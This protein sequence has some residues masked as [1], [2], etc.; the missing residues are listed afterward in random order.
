[1]SQAEIACETGI[2]RTTITD[3]LARLKDHGTPNKL[4]YPGHPRIT[5]AAQD[6]CI[7]AASEANTHI[8]FAQLSNIVNIL[9]S[10]STM[11]RRLH[12]DNI[13][14][15][16]AVKRVLLTEQHAAKRLQWARE[17]QH[18]TREDWAKVNW[19]DE[20]AVQKDSA[21]QQVWV[22]WHQTKVEKYAPKNVKSKARDG[23]V[24]Q[25]IWGCF[26]SNKLGP[27]VFLHGIVNSD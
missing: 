2:T 27:I 20:C 25:M 24:F 9:A 22:F 8:P 7:I 21:K 23:D 12:E 15:W 4:S 3:F 1:M 5:T 17:H 19:L 6:K 13:S 26:T 14:K 16:R 11:R 18:K 10:L